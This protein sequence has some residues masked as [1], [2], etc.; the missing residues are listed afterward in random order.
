ME[1]KAEQEF[2]IRIK[3]RR[4]GEVFEMHFFYSG[5][6]QNVSFLLLL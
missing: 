5:I 1:V 3:G 2:D 6:M 4:K